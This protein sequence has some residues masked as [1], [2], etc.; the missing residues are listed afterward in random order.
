M[1]KDDNSGS[2]TPPPLPEVGERALLVGLHPS[3]TVLFAEGEVAET[4]A[5]DNDGHPRVRIKLTGPTMATRA[6]VGYSRAYAD[7]YDSIFGK[8]TAKNDLN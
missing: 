3:G 1:K 7:N 8:R 5:P 4:L 6:T 2:S